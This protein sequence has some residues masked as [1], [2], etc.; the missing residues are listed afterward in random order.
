[1]G[2]NNNN[3]IQDYAHPDDQ[4]QPT[5]EMTPGFK[6]FTIKKELKTKIHSVENISQ[7]ELSDRNYQSFIDTIDELKKTEWYVLLQRKDFKYTSNDTVFS[8]PLV[9]RAFLA[10]ISKKQNELL[11]NF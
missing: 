3:P 2:V 8:V 10:S 9:C 6:P 11:A 1:M 7:G 5:F 4:T